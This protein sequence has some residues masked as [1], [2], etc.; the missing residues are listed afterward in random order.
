MSEA[1]FFPHQK[2]AKTRREGKW[3]PG[4]NA[5]REFYMTQRKAEH[6][7]F[8]L[9][10]AVLMAKSAAVLPIYICLQT[11]ICRWLP[12]GVCLKEDP[13]SQCKLEAW[14]PGADAGLQV[15][16]DFCRYILRNKVEIRFWKTGMTYI[17]TWEIIFKT[18]HIYIFS[19]FFS[20]FGIK[21]LCDSWIKTLGSISPQRGNRPPFMQAFSVCHDKII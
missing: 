3:V 10:P 16:A 19:T 20:F 5:L 15:S 2:Q 21:F 4:E 7:Y 13:E 18:F 1:S 8:P 14:P 6:I 12:P 11:G 17:R 9:L